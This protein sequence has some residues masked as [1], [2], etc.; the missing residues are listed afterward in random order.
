ME[1]SLIVVGTD[2]TNHII[3]LYLA[4]VDEETIV[5]WDW[6]LENLRVHIIG[7]WYGVCLISDRAPG[8]IRAIE[9]NANL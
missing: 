3:H 8:I 4:I 6:F 1:K 5:S 2:T 9:R 7:D